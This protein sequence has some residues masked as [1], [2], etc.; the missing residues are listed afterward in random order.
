[1]PPQPDQRLARGRIPED[2]RAVGA[3]RGKR[4]AIARD[5]DRRDKARVFVPTLHDS[6]LGDVPNQESAFCGSG[7]QMLS[8]GGKDGG[9][10]SAR[11]LREI[12]ADG[13]G[14]K[15][16]DLKL[17]AGLSSIRMPRRDKEGPVRRESHGAPRHPNPTWLIPKK[18]LRL[19]RL[20]IPDSITTGSAR[21]RPRG[22]RDQPLPV[23]GEHGGITRPWQR[24]LFLPGLGARSE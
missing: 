4:P 5:R 10:E 14:G 13:E 2:E 17:V 24:P 21:A 8:I 20:G 9:G 16:P 6:A 23:R 3:R 11:K 18:A 12:R 15:I 22:A 7:Q 1:M 19:P